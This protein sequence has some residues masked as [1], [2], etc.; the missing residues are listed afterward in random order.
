[1]TDPKLAAVRREYRHVAD[2]AYFNT[3]TF[4]SMAERVLERVCERIAH[5][6]RHGLTVYEELLAQVEAVRRRL[7]ARIGAAPEEIALT[8]NATDGVNLVAAGLDWQPGDEVL[9]SD[10]EHPAMAFPWTWAAQTRGL[11]VRRFTVEHDPAATL[12]NVRA[13]IGPRTRLI[14]ASWVT[15]PF[16]IRL[17]AREICRLARERGILSLI[18]G[19]QA[20]AVFPVDVRSLGCDCF[21]S[22]GHKWL[23]GPKGTGFFWARADL[24]ARL[25]PAHVGAGSEARYDPEAGLVLRPDGRRFEFA[26]T[27]HTLWAGLGP[28]LDW[29]DE[30]GWDWVE[31]RT[32]RLSGY[33]KDGLAQLG[34]VELK[35]PRPFERSSGLVT[36]A[37]P[38]RDANALVAHLVTQWRVR[39]RSLHLPGHVR[40]STAY[41]NT[42]EEIERLLAGVRSFAERA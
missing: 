40:V 2:V 28:A 42:D 37:L 16:G 18:D 1:M 17:P 21:T 14:G 33:L 10:Q 27:T 11:V 25:R 3:G 13:L 22:N 12:R 39:P 6:E 23:C 5:F 4:G 34:G 15:S 24:M 32:A 9:I 20:F 31:A 30:L 19:A 41:F 26:T 35:T 29:F 38:G 7:A 36:F 8:R